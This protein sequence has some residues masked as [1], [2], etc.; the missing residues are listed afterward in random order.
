MLLVEQFNSDY[1]NNK[2]WESYLTDYYYLNICSLKESEGE[3]KIDVTTNSSKIKKFI[4]K[5]KKYII[6]VTY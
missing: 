4:L 5:N 2:Y 1:I 3:N 6:C